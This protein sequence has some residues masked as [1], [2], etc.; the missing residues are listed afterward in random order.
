MLDTGIDVPAVVNLVFFKPVR[1]KT[2]FWQMVG[3]GTRLCPNLFGPGR[4]KTEFYIFDF[5]GNLEFFGTNP[6]AADGSASESLGK[7]LFKARLELVGELDKKA[8]DAGEKELRADT[9]GRLRDEVAAMNLNN[10]VV[11]PKRMLV[12]EYAKAEAW[13]ALTDEA[14][15]ALADE[16]A[17]LPSELPAEPEES[18]RFDLLLLRLHLAVLLVEPSFERLRDQVKGIAGLLEE[19][20]AIPMVRE[21]IELIHDLQ[22]DEWWQDV[23]VPMLESVR[24]RLRDLVRFIEKARRRPIYADFEDEVGQEAAIE[25]PGF[26]VGSVGDF[27]KFRLKA[28]AFLRQQTGAGALRKLRGNEP[29]TPA[30]LAELEELLAKSGGTAEAIRQ[31]TDEAHGLGVFVRSL[32]GLDREAAKRAFGG[33]LAGSTLTANQ[34][35]FVNLV[36]DHLTEHGVMEAGALYESPFTDVAPSGPDGLFTAPQV[37]ELMAI[38]RGFHAAALA[39]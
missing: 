16:V 11:R 20:E 38:L 4:H 10:F 36:V 1:S 34:I 2:K 8:E 32:V 12:E 28:R 13:A 9:A 5:C 39:A 29:L 6:D 18:K 3:R 14:R 7:R 22:S 17:G 21:H 35:E 27:E 15:H 26:G 19:K 24:K 23:T 33:F 30:D 31:A 25:L 37:Q